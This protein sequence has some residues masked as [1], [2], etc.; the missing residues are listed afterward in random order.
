M[1]TKQ[2]EQDVSPLKHRQKKHDVIFLLLFLGCL[3]LFISLFS[4]NPE[5]TAWSVE[6]REPVTNLAGQVGAW[7]SDLL[8]HLLVVER[9]KRIRVLHEE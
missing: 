5:D 4:Y 2:A 7:L 3:L 1:P 8:F 9:A 6:G